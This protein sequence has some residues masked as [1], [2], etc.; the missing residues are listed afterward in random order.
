MT[1]GGSCDVPEYEATE[2]F[3]NERDLALNELKRRGNP[4]YQPDA[5]YKNPSI[6]TESFK[7]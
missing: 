5:Y 6:R 7:E 3:R 4:P 1:L 2:S